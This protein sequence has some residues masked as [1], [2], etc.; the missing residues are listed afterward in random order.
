M[1]HGLVGISSP[2]FSIGGVS[3]EHMIVGE[4]VL[5]AEILGGLS[6][7]SDYFR[8]GAYLRL[9]ESHTYLH[10]QPPFRNPSRIHA[11]EWS[12]QQCILEVNQ[13]PAISTSQALSLRT[14]VSSSLGYSKGLVFLV[15]FLEALL[16]EDFSCHQVRFVLPRDRPDL[17]S[18]LLHS[19]SPS[20]A[21]TILGSSFARRS[22]DGRARIPP[23]AA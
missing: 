20:T 18:L 3:T 14:S 1:E 23:Q 19:S 7:V 21:L 17:V 13:A 22:C 16:R 5:V 10:T 8:V 11:K 2:A 6:V 4:E 9:W 12:T 15:V